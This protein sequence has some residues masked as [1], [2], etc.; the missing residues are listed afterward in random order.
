MSSSQV[1]QGKQSPLSTTSH[2]S[3]K[4]KK[5][6][7]EKNKP[8]DGVDSIVTEQSRYQDSEH[9][10]SYDTDSNKLSL[11]A[12][13]RTLEE[14]IKHMEIEYNAKFDALHRVIEANNK[15]LSKV[16]QEVGCL[17]SEIAHLKASSNF[18]T[19]ETSDI[20][21]KAEEQNFVLQKNVTELKEKTNDLEDRSRTKSLLAPLVPTLRTY[22]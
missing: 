6:N 5:G 8:K 1:G 2:G 10:I 16:N 20:K 18:L 11:M 4:P 17:K 15:E 9:E 3:H 14:K 13:N 21:N 7:K 12:I 22:N 19:K